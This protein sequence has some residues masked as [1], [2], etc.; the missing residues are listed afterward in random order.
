MGMSSASS[1]SL[2]SLSAAQ[3]IPVRQIITW[4]L[5]IREADADVTHA[6]RSSP[7]ASRK[8]LGS[9]PNALGWPFC[10]C[11]SKVKISFVAGF[12]LWQFKI[13]AYG[14]S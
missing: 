2:T 6:V 1:V 10:R 8:P 3:G 5:D 9:S 14:E 11:E 12:V 13:H 4:P 7:Q